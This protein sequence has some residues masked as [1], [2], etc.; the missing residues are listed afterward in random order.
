MHG[1]RANSLISIISSCNYILVIKYVSS[2]LAQVA[3]CK[4]MKNK[5]ME[6]SEEG[7]LMTALVRP[8]IRIAALNPALAVVAL[9]VRLSVG[10]LR[11]F[12]QYH[13]IRSNVSA[14][15]D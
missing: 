3:R 4:A 10:P 11:L 5:F 12:Q 8:L 2:R 13:Q 9:P 7:S 6:R 15:P 1:Y 14:N